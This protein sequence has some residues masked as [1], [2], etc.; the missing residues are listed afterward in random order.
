MPRCRRCRI[1][2]GRKSRWPMSCGVATTFPFLPFGREDRE[3]NFSRFDTSGV[4]GLAPHDLTAFVFTDRGIYRPG[5]D[6]EARPDRQ[7]ARLA[8]ETRRCPA[9]P[10]RR[11]SAR[12]GGAE[13]AHETQRE[14]ISRGDI[15]N[16]GDLANREIPGQL[17]SRERAATTTRCSVR[18]RCAWRNSC[19]TG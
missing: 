11:R 10:G 13:P 19:P 18:R 4:A 7:A 1:S 15:S 14:R 5:D 9:P 2:R 3:L 12:N 6:R 17:L 16:A 8:G